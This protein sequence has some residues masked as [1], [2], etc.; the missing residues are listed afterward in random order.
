MNKKT[1]ID[2]VQWQNSSKKIRRCLD[3]ISRDISTSPSYD[4]TTMSDMFQCQ[5]IPRIFSPDDK[6]IRHLSG[7]NLYKDG[8]RLATQVLNAKPVQPPMKILRNLELYHS[9]LRTEALEISQSFVVLCGLRM[10]ISGNI[11]VG[12]HATL[13]IN[14]CVV[15]CQKIIVGEIVFW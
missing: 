4:D 15:K 14:H 11:Y 1:K 7:L 3:E 2:C 10:E 8:T 5:N 12:P 6:Y 13:Y 9:V